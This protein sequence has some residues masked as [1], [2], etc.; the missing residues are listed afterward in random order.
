MVNERRRVRHRH[1][2]SDVSYSLDIERLIRRLERR[3][4]RE[5]HTE[6]L[7]SARVI[8]KWLLEGDWKAAELASKGGIPPS[9]M[10]LVSNLRKEIEWKYGEPPETRISKERYA[11]AGE[12]ARKVTV[13][14]GA[15]LSF[16]DRL[17]S[18]TLSYYTGIPFL[19]LVFVGIFA[20]LFF[21]GGFLE[22]IIT[23]LFEDG[24]IPFIEN[25]VGYTSFELY[26]EILYMYVDPSYTVLVKL[27]LPQVHPYPFLVK[28]LFINGAIVGIEAVFA[29]AVPYILTFYIVLAILEDTGYL[30]RIAF[31]L[32][33]VMHKFGLHGK[34]IIP[35][36]A[37]LGCNVPA[38][39]STR[40]LES[41]KQRLIASFLIV[42][43]PCSAR[44]SVILGSVAYY[45]GISYALIVYS[46][47]LGV[48]IVS[49]LV[50]SKILPGNPSG[51]VMEMPPY[52][53]PSLSA[54][55]KK[56][57]FR[58]REFIY[59]A[60]PLMI[61]GSLILGLLSYFKILDA[62]IQPM[63]PFM[64]NWLGLP[65]ITSITLIYGLLRKEMT[66]Q[67]LLV[68]SQL[69]L[70][71]TN[72]G[73]LLTPI[74]MIVYAVVVALYFPC[75]AAFSVLARETGIKWA[76][77]V[78]II[79]VVLALTLGGIIWHLHLFLT[80]GISFDQFWLYYVN[81]LTLTSIS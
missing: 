60:L 14:K 20:L 29:I 54:V 43:V 22:G 51:L 18:I 76:V 42:L 58:V 62:V 55:L 75:V 65:S 79:T 10:Q 70:G 21:G 78:S 40:I 27:L 50:L 63:Q 31:L 47:I 46:I 74:Q 52:Q 69:K 80:S 61:A 23:G 48:V 41:R 33:N 11:L 8:A 56:T 25:I 59:I 3:I 24:I 34:S 57:W 28:D 39:M 53:V 7:A 26:T 49:G 72:L 1:R 19:L 35:L 6:D 77:T 68:I 2:F 12:I 71:V 9:I 30:T 66:I 38:L 17:D 5:I 13:E 4:M 15:K 73:L 36:L 64:A 81:F 37:S 44:T 32:D 45:V 16:R 67:T